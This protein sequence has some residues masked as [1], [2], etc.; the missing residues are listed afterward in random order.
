MNGSEHLLK[1]SESDGF[2]CKVLPPICDLHRSYGQF[3]LVFTK[4]DE[5]LPSKL[6]AEYLYLY[7]IHIM[8]SVHVIIYVKNIPSLMHT[9]RTRETT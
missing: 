3:V 6:L 5:S 7:S 8:L 2:R 9:V 1:I 4:T